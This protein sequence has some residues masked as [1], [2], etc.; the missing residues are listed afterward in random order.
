[1]PEHDTLR[2]FR[3]V[4]VPE[5]RVVSDLT[6]AAID[7]ERAHFFDQIKVSLGLGSLGSQIYFRE[8]LHTL[9]TRRD[10]EVAVEYLDELWVKDNEII[11]TV[12]REEDREGVKKVIFSKEEQISD[13]SLQALQ[14]IQASERLIDG[15]DSEW[16]L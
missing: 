7:Q 1:M 10:P 12:F 3:G 8:R 15:L 5:T 11:A 16:K 4:E 13:E 2:A 14:E 6:D 9:R